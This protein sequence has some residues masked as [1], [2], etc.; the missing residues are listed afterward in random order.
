MICVLCSVV[1][2]TCTV[3]VYCVCVCAHTRDNF[4]ASDRG[5][6][7]VCALTAHVQIIFGFKCPKFGSSFIILLFILY[8]VVFYSRS[9][10]FFACFSTL[11]FILSFQAFILQIFLFHLFTHSLPSFLSPSTS[12]CAFFLFTLPPL[13]TVCLR[14]YNESSSLSRPSFPDFLCSSSFFNPF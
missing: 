1:V 4:T 3:H 12:A 5:I 13:S 10:S 14:T 6:G 2:Y 7:R 11:S 8:L 9:V